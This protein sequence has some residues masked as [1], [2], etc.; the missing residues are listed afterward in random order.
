MRRHCSSHRELLQFYTHKKTFSSLQ[1]DICGQQGERRNQRKRLLPA[2]VQRARR[3]WIRAGHVQ[4]DK[5]CFL[6]PTEGTTLLWSKEKS[7]RSEIMFIRKE[8]E[9][10]AQKVS[11]ANRQFLL[12][13][14]CLVCTHAHTRPSPALMLKEA[15]KCPSASH[16]DVQ[17][18]TLL[19]REVQQTTYN[20]YIS[21]HCNLSLFVV[22]WIVKTV[23][24]WR[25]LF[26]FPGR[27]K[28]FFS[29]SEPVD[30]F[31]TLN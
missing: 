9:W 17:T 31:F 21:S 18:T 7:H 30:F 29:I 6:V 23:T 8:G 12:I 22:C 10:N 20:Y 3:A 14:F 26:D 25:N 15:K 27:A 16:T 2:R 4:R 11:T 24:K 28:L 5:D 19:S 1:G 13:W